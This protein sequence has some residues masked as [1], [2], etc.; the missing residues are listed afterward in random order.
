MHAPFTAQFMFH[1]KG[2]CLIFLLDTTMLQFW[3]RP[4]GVWNLRRTELMVNQKVAEGQRRNREPCHSSLH[5]LQLTPTGPLT[6]VLTLSAVLDARTLSIQ[7]VMENFAMVCDCC[8]IASSFIYILMTSPFINIR[9]NTKMGSSSP[10]GSPHARSIN[11][12]TLKRMPNYRA[13]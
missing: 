5:E 11:A 1:T 7:C 6:L 9:E 12:R 3:L 10:F 4:T 2:F 8:K 13:C